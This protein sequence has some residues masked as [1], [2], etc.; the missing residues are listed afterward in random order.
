MNRQNILRKFPEDIDILNDAVDG[1]VN[2]EDE[3]PHIYKKIYEFYDVRGLQLF[4]DPDDDYEVVLT[5]L[6]KDL[7]ILV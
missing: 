6:E 7:D 1:V 2:L 4:G 5:Q 3:Y